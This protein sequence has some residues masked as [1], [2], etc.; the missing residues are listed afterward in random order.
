MNRIA[1]LVCVLL[2]GLYVTVVRSWSSYVGVVVILENTVIISVTN[3][4]TQN[5]N[6]RDYNQNRILG[7]TT[8]TKARSDHDSSNCKCIC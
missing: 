1:F 8:T 7:N 2:V 4:R 5:N 6:E 3:R